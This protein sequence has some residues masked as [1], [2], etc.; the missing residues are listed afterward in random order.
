MASP[1]RVSFDVSQCVMACVLVG[2]TLNY[3]ALYVHH[4]TR[5]CKF[6][7]ILRLHA[8]KQPVSHS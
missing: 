4:G 2:K 1:N 7:L 6:L 8:V 5:C 3:Q